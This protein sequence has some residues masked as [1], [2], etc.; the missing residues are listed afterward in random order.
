[1]T[2]V[3]IR[4]PEEWSDEFVNL[5]RQLRLID[6]GDVELDLGPGDSVEPFDGQAFAEWV[7][8]LSDSSIPIMTAILGFLVAKRGECEISSEDKVYKFKSMKTSK[9]REVMDIIEGKKD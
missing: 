6:G 7:I 3:V 5:W 4:I 9:I 2:N 1:M 8:I